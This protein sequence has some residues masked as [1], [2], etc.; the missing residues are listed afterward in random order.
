MVRATRW[1]NALAGDNVVQER[2]TDQAFYIIV[3]GS[4]A[5]LKN[6][7]RIVTRLA[8]TSDHLSKA[9]DLK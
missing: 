2:E 8:R 1:V 9:R 4:A 3:K 7:S 5:V 6:D